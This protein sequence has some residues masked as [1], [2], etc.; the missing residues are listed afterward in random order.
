MNGDETIRVLGPEDSALYRRVRLRALADAPDAFGSL[1]A[2]AEL[3]PDSLWQ[4]QLRGP[5]P[6]V[7]STQD[8]EPVAMG[9]AFVGPDSAEARL[10]GMWTAPEARGHGHA[11]RVLAHLLAWCRARDLAVALDVTEGNDPARALY[12]AHGF[13]PTG[14]WEPLREG[15]SL[16]AETMRLSDG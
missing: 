2:D 1:V 16:R 5:G 15:S 14:E 6:V 4:D 7:V 10:W 13:R 11:T 12:V 9:G 3:K 8:G